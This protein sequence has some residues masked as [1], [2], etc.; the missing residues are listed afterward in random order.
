MFLSTGEKLHV[1]IWIEIPINDQ[2]ISRL[3][4]LATNDKNP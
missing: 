3:N 2:V 4:D 1:F